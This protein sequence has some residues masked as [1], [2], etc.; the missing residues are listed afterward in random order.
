MNG[1]RAGDEIQTGKQAKEIPSNKTI[2][3]IQFVMCSLWASINLF[4]YIQDIDV[5]PFCQRFTAIEIHTYFSGKKASLL[6][7]FLNS[8]AANAEEN[9]LCYDKR[10]KNWNRQNTPFVFR[11]ILCP[12]LTW[13]SC[14]YIYRICMK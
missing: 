4:W 6:L 10:K 8:F 2:Y 11:S 1:I 3:E 7:H 9:H 14:D 13:S 5:Q 12:F